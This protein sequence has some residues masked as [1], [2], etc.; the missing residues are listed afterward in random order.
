MLNLRILQLASVVAIAL[1]SPSQAQS[2]VGSWFIQNAGDAKS[3]AVLTFL[4]NGTYTMAEDG[5]STL[6]P[7]GTDGMERGTYTWNPSTKKFTVKTLVDTTREWGLSHSEFEKVLVS[8]DTLTLVA[9]DGKFSLARVTS[10]TNELAGGWYINTGGT[11]YAVVTFLANGTYFMVQDGKNNGGGRTGMEHGTYKWNP[12]TKS[13]TRKLRVDTN[14]S[15]G[16]S[17]SGKRSISVSG[18]KLTLSVKGEGKF[19]VR[20]ATSN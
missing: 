20:R 1:V 4:P 7:N 9:S 16:F 18:N 12:A 19:V 15:W 3:T 10:K 13:F 5:N 11:S 14:G 17:D 6:D 8:N 2:I